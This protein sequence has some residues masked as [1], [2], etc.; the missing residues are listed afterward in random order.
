[1]QQS[2]I[3]LVNDL[4]FINTTPRN[5]MQPQEHEHV[6]DF[7][8]GKYSFDAFMMYDG[9]IIIPAKN[10]SICAQEVLGVCVLVIVR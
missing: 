3:P 8:P 1:M 9:G 10:T 7:V 6:M 5:R 4:N 2:G